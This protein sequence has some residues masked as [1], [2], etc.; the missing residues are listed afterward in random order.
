MAGRMQRVRKTS[1]INWDLGSV[2]G[3]IS[4]RMQWIEKP[5]GI[6]WEFEESEKV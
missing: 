2:D 4:E 6:I 1:R 5:S 3:F